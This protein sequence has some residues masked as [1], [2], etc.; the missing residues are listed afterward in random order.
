MMKRESLKQRE[1]RIGY[2]K[3]MGMTHDRFADNIICPK[4]E[5]DPCT[6][7]YY[8]LKDKITDQDKKLNELRGGQ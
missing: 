4:C 2:Q 3:A 8:A 7:G 5:N 6:C 1:Q